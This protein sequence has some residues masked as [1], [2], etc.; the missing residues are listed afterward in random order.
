MQNRHRDILF[1]SL[2]VVVNLAYRYWLVSASGFDGLY[3]QDAFA[4]FNFAEDLSSGITPRPFFFPL[5]Y[6]LLL[7]IPFRLFGASANLALSIMIGMATFIPVLGYI[8]G[9][10]LR[11]SLWAAFT[12]G[13]LLSWSPQLVQSGV[14]I[15]A[16]IPALFWCMLSMVSVL[17]YANSHHRKWLLLTAIALGLA[18]ITRWIYVVQIIPILN[19]Y[20]IRL[21]LATSLA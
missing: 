8:L 9:R 20:R 6:P 15:M 17:E 16:D 2:L 7:A 1:I 12:V 4:Y 5:G 14:V 10:Q 19:L 11:L 18:I 3:G 13:L 21:G